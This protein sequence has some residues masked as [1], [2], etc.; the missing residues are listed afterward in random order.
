MTAAA[1]VP[2][3]APRL[4]RGAAAR[5]ALAVLL[6]LG[7]LLTLGLLLGGPAHAA[8][9][10]GTTDRL[11]GV[12]GTGTAVVDGSVRTGHLTTGRDMTDPVAVRSLPTDQG[13]TDQGTTDRG[14]TDQGATD[15]GTTDRLGGAPGTG[16][17][18]VDGSVTTNHLTTGRVTTDRVTTD[19]LTTDPVT[20]AVRAVDGADEAAEPVVGAVTAPVAATAGDV[21]GALPGLTETL[22]EV[23]GALPE[24]PSTAP[25]LPA[26]PTAL[27]T[28]PVP[29]GPGAP[30]VPPAGAWGDPDA[31]RAGA[32]PAAEGTGRDAAA[33]G[34]AAAAHRPAAAHLHPAAS[35]A[36]AA[37]A[38]AH[39]GTDA[40]AAVPSPP[41][42][43]GPCGGAVRQSAA[44]DGGTPRPGDQQ[45]VASP[46]D[47]HTAP[48]P[49]T[50]GPATA[51]PVRDRPHDVLEFPG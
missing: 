26:P 27:P 51:A 14:T 38:T 34:G 37:T 18:V 31:T 9:T 10:G 25:V 36:T 21:T 11:G 3:T 29:S 8:E 35:G 43:P 20:A 50:A 6:F 12:P 17:A 1:V 46:A 5:R 15:R 32:G 45:A 24:V 28:L 13:T 47:A 16:T 2:A 42:G 4:A 41:F 23:V 39:R 48:A 7:G 30:H 49:G 33:P 19:S 44:G 40:Y 22:S